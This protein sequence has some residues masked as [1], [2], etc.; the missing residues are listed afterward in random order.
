MKRYH[1]FP[2]AIP[3]G[4]TYEVNTIAGYSPNYRLTAVAWQNILEYLQQKWF[5]RFPFTLFE[6]WVSWEAFATGTQT[7]FFFW[8]PNESIG[9]NVLDRI[10]QEHIEIDYGIIEN[11]FSLDFSKPHWGMKLFLE[12]NYSVPIEIYSNNSIDSLTQ[13]VE[14]LSNATVGQELMIQYLVRPV[15][16]HQ[17]MRTFKKAYQSLSGS[18]TADRDMY[19][20]AIH[21][22]MEQMKAEIAIK[23]IG[24]A[25]T[26]KDAQR[27][28]E[29]CYKSLAYLNSS[30][31]NRFVSREW[32]RTFRPLYRYELEHRI[33]PFRRPQNAVILGTPEMAGLLRWPTLSGSSK[34]IRTKMQ[35]PLAQ[36]LV[37][38]IANEPKTIYI[39]DSIRF[40]QVAPIHLSQENLDN[41]VTV[42]GAANSGKSSFILNLVDDFIKL[43]TDENRMGF[44][45]I[46][47]KGSLADQ[48]LARIPPE[49][50]GK[51]HVIRA[52]E[53]KFPFNPFDIDYGLTQR[54]V[55]VT[56]MIARADSLNWKPMVSE[57]ITIIGYALD[58]LGIANLRNVQRV[59]EDREF[60]NWVVNQLDE[61]H[62]KVASLKRTLQR[63]VQKDP[64]KISW[65]R[66][67][68]ESF[69][70]ARLRNLNTSSISNMINSYTSG[71]KWLQAWEEGQMIII[72]LSGIHQNDQRFLVS[73]IVCHYEMGMISRTQKNAD[74]NLAQHP[75]IMDEGS[76]FID[77]FGSI[78]NMATIYRKYNMPLIISLQGLQSHLSPNAIESFFRN[79]GTHAVFQL[80]NRRDAQ[81]VMDSLRS[82]SFS[83][84][85]RDYYLCNTGYCFMQHTV[86]RS[87]VFILKPKVVAPAKYAGLV[88]KLAAKSL[89]KV[90]AIEEQRQS[91]IQLGTKPIEQKKKVDSFDQYVDELYENDAY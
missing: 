55:H 2:K 70:M 66:E 29:Q 14:H 50:H 91:Q 4:V 57:T 8:A 15:Y 26:T 80:G 33:F 5:R 85:V 62:P 54:G 32:W 53:G 6:P 74:G 37:Q 3:K 10:A 9:R 24:F 56:E 48:V 46:D 13:F 25:D 61:N 21:D 75:L 82:E 7:R 43:R 77:L 1:L 51:V 69:N 45:L 72:D 40:T 84:E 58:T 31:L 68:V 88:E 28:T 83:L 17:V 35:R 36:V 67:F 18:K 78:E 89:N 47:T 60:C 34:L 87:Q 59:I 42:I 52:R 64:H 39:G 30:E 65:P 49:Q 44:T 19:Q 81:I 41:H 27:L 63:Y 38:K 16:D 79:F 73:C 22:K 86:D 23:I 12:R 20:Q 76:G 11:P 71:V 90:L